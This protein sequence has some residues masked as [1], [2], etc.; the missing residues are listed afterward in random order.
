VDP[1]E[2]RLVINPT[3]AEQVREI[4]RIANEASSLEALVSQIAACRFQTKAWT[5]KAGKPHPARAFSRMTL[6]L[7]HRMSSIKV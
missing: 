6:R 1:Q 3:E 4:F 7:L 2:G 5:S